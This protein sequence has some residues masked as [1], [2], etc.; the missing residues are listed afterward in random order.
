V[1]EHIFDLDQ[2]IAGVARL[3]APTGHFLSKS[4]FAEADSQHLHIHLAKHAPYAD[5]RRFN[6]LMD[7][8]RFGYRGQLKPNRLSRLLRACGLRYTVAGIRISPRLKHGGNFL[9]HV[10]R[11]H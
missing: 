5:V 11:D 8:H 6:E 3:L 10:K 1:L 2:A 9:V 4:T 7:R